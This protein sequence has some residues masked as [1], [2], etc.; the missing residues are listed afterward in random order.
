MSVSGKGHTSGGLLDLATTY[1]SMKLRNPMM[2]ASMGKALPENPYEAGLI[3]WLNSI[4]SREVVS[5][6]IIDI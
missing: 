4:C 5:V 6:C 1:V 2:P 3:L